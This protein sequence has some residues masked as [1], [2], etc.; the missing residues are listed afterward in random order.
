MSGEDVEEKVEAIATHVETGI[1]EVR[2]AYLEG[3]RDG[4]AQ[5]AVG[6]EG[7]KYAAVVLSSVGA[8]LKRDPEFGVVIGLPGDQFVDDQF[9]V[10]SF[11][12]YLRELKKIDPEAAEDLRY[13][14]PLEWSGDGD[15]EDL[16]IL[17]GSA[18]KPYDYSAEDAQAQASAAA[19]AR[20]AAEDMGGEVK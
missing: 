11:K 12:R 18:C 3:L 8:Q 10:E 17:S 15:D 9:A 1:S 20:E 2:Q 13:G 16:G 19:A 4:K 7:I 14:R 5:T 6:P